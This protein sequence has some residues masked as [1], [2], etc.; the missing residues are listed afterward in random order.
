MRIPFGPVTIE[1][2]VCSEA[3]VSVAVSSTVAMRVVPVDAEG[4]E[5]PDGAVAVVGGDDVDDVAVFMA[6][7]R[8]AAIALL[9]GRGV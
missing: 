3:E 8:D 7:V 2:Q 5:Y 4:V 9:D 6:A 1:D